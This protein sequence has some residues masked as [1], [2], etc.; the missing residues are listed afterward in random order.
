M[1]DGAALPGWRGENAAASAAESASHV[2]RAAEPHSCYR[3]KDRGGKHT[4]GWLAAALSVSKDRVQGASAS[5]WAGAPRQC[6]SS[7][8]STGAKRYSIDQTAVCTANDSL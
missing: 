2:E 4:P 5:S 3:V 6:F 7:A 1:T 8:L